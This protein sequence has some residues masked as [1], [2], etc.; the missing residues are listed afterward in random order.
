MLKKLAHRAFGARC[1]RSFKNVGILALAL[2]AMAVI[3][4][5][6]ALAADRHDDRGFGRDRGRVV[7]NWDRGPEARDHVRYA[8]APRY[9]IRYYRSRIAYP[10]GVFA[11]PR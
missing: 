11:C 7:Q 5:A 9:D 6:S 1:A 2:P 4:P 10:A 8:P 3:Q